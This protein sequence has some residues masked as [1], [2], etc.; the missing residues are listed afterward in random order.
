MAIRPIFV[1]TSDK[2]YCIRENV[3]F[4]FLVVFLIHKKERV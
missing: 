4:E 1:V 3:E 2:R